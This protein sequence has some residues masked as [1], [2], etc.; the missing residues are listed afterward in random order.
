MFRELNEQETLEFQ[1]WADDNYTP[2]SSI[3]SAWHPV[4]QKR[5]A[6]INEEFLVESQ[7]E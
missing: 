3:S 1:Q 6:E 5:C 4:V 2:G 7:A